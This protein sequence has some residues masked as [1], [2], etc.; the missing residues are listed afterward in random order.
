MTATIPPP[1]HEINNNI[2]PKSNSKCDSYLS[3]TQIFFGDAEQFSCWKSK[4]YS[5]DIVLDEEL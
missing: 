3:R 4:L 2:A 1:P 5:H